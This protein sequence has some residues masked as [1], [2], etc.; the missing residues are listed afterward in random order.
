MR[1]IRNFFKL[2]SFIRNKKEVISIDN[3][4]I[5]EK[6]L[7]FNLFQNS[8]VG[9]YQTTPKGKIISVNPAILKMLKF[10]SL[11]DI[12]KRDLSKGSYVDEAKKIVFNDLLEQEGEATNF[13]SQWYTKDREIITVK[14]GAKALKD[15]NGNTYL[16]VGVVEDITALVKTEQDLVKAKLKAEESDRLK[17]AFLLNMSHEIRTPLNGISGFAQ[18]F[19]EPDLSME[20]KEQYVNIILGSGQRLM[21]TVNDIMDI[22]KINSG[23][24]SL[25]L[26]ETNI[27]SLLIEILELQRIDSNKKDVE[28]NVYNQLTHKESSLITDKNKLNTILNN[29]IGNAVKFTEKGEINVYVEIDK[30]E[31]VFQIRDTG[32]GIP[33]DRLNAIFNSFEQADIMDKKAFQGSGLGL[34][35][36]Q[37]YIEKLEG[38][39]WLESEVDKGSSFY[40]T[41]PHHKIISTSKMKNHSTQSLP[42][43]KETLK[44]LIAEDDDVSYL[45]LTM[46]LKKTDYKIFHCKTGKEAVELCLKNSDLNIILMDIKMPEMTGH[47]ATREIRKFNKDVFIIAQTAYALSK[48]KDLALESGCNEYI[49]KPVDKDLLYKLID[50]YRLD[51]QKK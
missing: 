16:Y 29:I 41:I 49:S 36:A 42:K 4:F 26:S 1:I 2:F 12:M 19:L 20:E 47:D 11:D 9:L 8:T 39:I 48:D 22:A 6:H 3:S 18:L 7:Y 33:K 17:T 30:N 13:I 23:Q 45:Y 25:D 31:I 40:F 44:V 24:I 35:I 5:D 43:N 14:E 32:I 51:H 37:A 10:D 27:N 38:R 46:I 34:S 15:K 50:K 21:N 28:I